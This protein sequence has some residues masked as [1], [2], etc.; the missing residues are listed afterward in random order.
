MVYL[1][2]EN[3]SEEKDEDVDFIFHIIRDALLQLAQSKLAQ[4]DNLIVIPKLNN[5]QY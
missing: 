1:W 2:H 3:H 4:H 5:R